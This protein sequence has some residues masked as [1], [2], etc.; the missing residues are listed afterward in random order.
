[1]KKDE[2]N[3]DINKGFN[4]WGNGKKYN[5]NRERPQGKNGNSVMET[6]F[7]HTPAD[8]CA[9]SLPAASQIHSSV[10]PGPAVDPPATAPTVPASDATLNAATIEPA[11]AEEPAAV[12]DSQAA[13]PGSLQIEKENS[14]KQAQVGFSSGFIRMSGIP[15]ID[16]SL[17]H[18]PSFSNINQGE[19]DVFSEGSF[20]TDSIEVESRKTIVVGGSIGLNL[21]CCSEHVKNS[22]QEE[23]FNKI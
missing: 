3:N 4:C 16:D 14:N 5:N 1:M 20:N 2:V 9:S 6:F 13:F 8:R 7:P 23:R 10:A 22:I 12:T 19:N 17:S 11:A 21:N 15:S 18:P